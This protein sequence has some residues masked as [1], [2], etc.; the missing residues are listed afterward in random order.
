V[1][2]GASERTTTW[3]PA[4]TSSGRSRR[5]C[6]LA[7]WDVQRGRLFGRCETQTGIVAFGRLVEQVMTA[8]P[9]S[10]ARR[11]FWIVD[12]GS[13]HR[14]HVAAERLQIEW[15]NLVLVHLPF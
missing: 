12:N 3:S 14:G 6:Y 10:Q 2:G 13:S 9:Y 7:A 5:S 4:R 15:P 11:V 8:E 1:S